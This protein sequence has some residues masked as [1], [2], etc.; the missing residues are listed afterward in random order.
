MLYLSVKYFFNTDKII[1]R[2]VKVEA[3]PMNDMQAAFFNKPQQATM[4]TRERER[5]REQILT[6]PC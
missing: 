6:P 3:S 2:E 5:E 4:S 1:R